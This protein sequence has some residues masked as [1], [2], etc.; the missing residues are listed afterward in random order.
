[1]ANLVISG[2]T[3]GSVTLAAPAVSG[4]TVLTLPTTSGTIVTT[5]SAASLTT[6]GNLTFTGTGNRI[7]GDFSN[8]TIANRVAFQNS[9]TNAS[10]VVHAIP[11]GTGPTSGFEANNASDFTNSAALQ[12]FSSST[13]VS[14]R[15]AIRGTGTYLPL[16]MLTSNIERLRIDTSG[17]VGIGTSAPQSSLD[18]GVGST[19]APTFKG[20]IRLN[21]GGLAANGGLEFLNT[22]F[23]S[24]YGWRLQTPDEGGGST[25]IVFQARSNSASW[26]ERMRIDSNGK[27]ILARTDGTS[28]Q[29]IGVYNTTVGDSANVNI[30][31]D[32]AMYRSSS[33]RKY[34]KDIR[35]IEHIDLSL[36]KPVRYKSNCEADDQTKD[37]FGFI[38]D[39]YASSYPELVQ[40]GSDNEVEGFR[41][42]RMTVLLVKAIQE[43][44]AIITQ[45]QLDVAALK[46]AA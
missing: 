44:Q 7:L 10:T 33:A 26:T 38:A 16:T 22:T 19:S 37:Y 30:Q 6:S 1:M 41:Y 25:P 11:N 43:Q 28:L 8:S 39:D 23:A 32:G 9:S 29:A 15:S 5:G 27:L 31:S 46:G 13:E 21:G 24:G 4:T 12:L 2:D 34:K 18:V 3:S 42:D 45:L 40:F 17:N 35:D 20:H 36:F 14:I